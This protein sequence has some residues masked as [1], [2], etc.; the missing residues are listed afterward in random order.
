MDRYCKVEKIAELQGHTQGIYAMAQDEEGFLYTAGGDGILVRW[1]PLQ[2]D[3]GMAVARFPGPVYSLLFPDG[4]NWV[5]GAA[6]GELFMQANEGQV[7]RMLA[8][9]KGLFA[10]MAAGEGKWLSGGG[11]GR[12]MEW[13]DSGNASVLNHFSDQSLRVLQRLP[14]GAVAAGYSDAQIRIWGSDATATPRALNAHSGSVFALAFHPQ[15]QRLYSAGRDARLLVWDMADGCALINDIKAHLLHIHHMDLS[16]DGKLLA[17][18]SM[19]KTIRIWD[20]HS[21][22]LLKVI[23]AANA[24]AHRSSVNR[25][26]WLENRVLASAGDDRM[27]RVFR[28]ELLSD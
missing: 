5:A 13:N 14:D 17:T 8:H 11:D 18:A 6:S 9:Q 28:L 26:L 4:G 22:Q 24:F 15:L 1:Q 12:C 16:P 21:L 20:S 7:R 3:T 2:S 19:D 10:L 23:G 25:V 27:L